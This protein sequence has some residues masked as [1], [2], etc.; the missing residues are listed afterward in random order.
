MAVVEAFVSHLHIESKFAD[1]LRDRLSRDFIGL[2]RVFVSSDS[3]SIPVGTQWLDGIL[4]AL[5]Q[6]H[7]QLI[8]CSRESVRRPWL[9]YEAGGAV[10]RGVEVIPLCHSGMSPDQLPVPLSMSQGAMLTTSEGLQKLYTRISTLLGSDVPPV[11]FV[12][13]AAAF[14]ALE[15]EY[16]VQQ[17]EQSAASI[18]RSAESIVNPTVLCVSSQQY[19][20][21][22]YEN[23]L[24]DVLDSFPKDLRHDRVT[25]SAELE[26]VLVHNPVAIVHVAA[27]VCPRTGAMYFTPVRLPTGEN[28]T[29]APDFIRAG[30][31]ARLIEK[32]GTRLVVIA[33][34]D[35]LALATVLLPVTNVIVPSDIV[36]AQAMASWIRTFYAALS[37]QP[38]ADA[39][40]YAQASTL[41]PMQLLTQQMPIAMKVV[42]K[43]VG[44][45]AS[46]S[47]GH[48]DVDAAEV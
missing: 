4:A 40:E 5:K 39:C 2:V 8:I 24:Q 11:D 34:G 37:V 44:V 10:I 32:A 6:A 26:R 23:Q 31:F 19:L 15:E 12:S 9:H 36:S 29:N 45:A 17:K 33:S 35:S 38:L 48:R 7:V 21:M 16:A 46:E 30:A 27:Y 25:T 1:L 20:Q 3:T 28:E 41:A 47:A 43:G 14:Q 22:G 42:F 13:F 18:C